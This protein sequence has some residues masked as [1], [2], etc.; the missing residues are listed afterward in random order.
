VFSPGNATE[1]GTA[2]STSTGNQSSGSKA[3]VMYDG[4]INAFVTTVV[5]TTAISAGMALAADGAGNLT[6]AGASPAV[7]TVLATALGPVASSTSVPALI[8][9]YVGG[10]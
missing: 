2:F 10:Y 7:G 9:V 4:P 1:A 5:N 3:V 6:Y 8:P